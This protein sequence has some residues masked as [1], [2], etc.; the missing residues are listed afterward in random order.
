MTK[1]SWKNYKAALD[2]ILIKTP[3]EDVLPPYPRDIRIDTR[4]N[5][6]GKWFLP[7]K[8]THFNGH[9]FIEKAF[10]EGAAGAFCE[11][12]YKDKIPNSLHGKLIF[13]T[14][15]LPALQKIASC[16]REHNKETIVFAITG[17]IGKTSTK[18]LLASILKQTGEKT[19]L[20]PKNFNN[21]LGL[22][23]TLLQLEKDHKYAILEMGARKIGDIQFLK[24]IAKPDINLCLCVGSAHIGTFGSKENIYTGKLE[25]LERTVKEQKNLVLKDD[26]LLLSKALE[27]DSNCYTYGTSEGADAELLDHKLLENGRSQVTIKLF[28]RIFSTTLATEHQGLMKNA[29]A[30]SLLASLGGVGL[31]H[32]KKGLESFCPTE[33]RFKAIE[34]DKIIFVDDSYNASFESMKAGIESLIANYPEKKLAC[35]LG[36]MQDLGTFSEAEHKKLAELCYEKN[37]SSIITI[38]EKTG[39]SFKS[40]FADKKKKTKLFHFDSSCHFVK[41]GFTPEEFGEVLYFKGALSMDLKKI[42]SYFLTL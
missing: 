40:I 30:A 21:E 11:E 28:G 5:M 6:G 8:G 36:D 9:S 14:E 12:S 25:I 32:I 42:V 29:V 13:V 17:S 19:L 24:K 22:P 3:G 2:T 4:G 39:Q 38:G 27:I 34:K 1:L 41:G 18:N 26:T 16:I 23:L 35:F 31:D 15:T 33:S 37:L 7:L 10:E 20:A